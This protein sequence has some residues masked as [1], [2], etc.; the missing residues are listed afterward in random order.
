MNFYDIVHPLFISR[1]EASRSIA[2]TFIVVPASASLG[3]MQ[4]IRSFA[5]ELSHRFSDFT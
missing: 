3:G 2:M 4:S 5:W 1:D